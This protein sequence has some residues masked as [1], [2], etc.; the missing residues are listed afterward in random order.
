MGAPRGSHPSQLLRRCH[1]APLPLTRPVAHECCSAALWVLQHRSATYW[2]LY[3]YYCQH[4]QQV[5][6]GRW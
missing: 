6:H 1:G 4:I 3:D 2:A 5:G